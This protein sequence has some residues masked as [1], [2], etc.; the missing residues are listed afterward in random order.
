MN[1][2]TRADHE[3]ECRL[4]SM[5]LVERIREDYERIKFVIDEWTPKEWAD[6]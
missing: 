1:R 5:F 4:I 6:R 2:P 3:E